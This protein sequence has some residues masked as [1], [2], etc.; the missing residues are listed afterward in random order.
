MILMIKDVNDT[1]PH[2]YIS[3]NLLPQEIFITYYLTFFDNFLYFY[4]MYPTFNT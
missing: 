1:K 3:S 4:V 2:I